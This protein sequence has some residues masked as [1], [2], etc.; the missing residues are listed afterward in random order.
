MSIQSHTDTRGYGFA[1]A[2]WVRFSRLRT[3]WV[4][5]GYHY[6]FMFGALQPKT[7]AL[8]TDDDRIMPLLPNDD[9]PGPRCSCAECLEC[10]K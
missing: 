2:A 10:F 5:D 3:E 7:P 9:H 6:Y 4:S 8:V 1:Y